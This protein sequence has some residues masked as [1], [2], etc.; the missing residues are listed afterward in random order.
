MLTRKS[1]V[2][3]RNVLRC[4]D[5]MMSVVVEGRRPYWWACGASGHMSKAY[6]NKMQYLGIANQQQRKQQ[7]FLARLPI[8][9][10]GRWQRRDGSHRESRTLQSSKNNPKGG[11]GLK[12]SGVRFLKPKNASTRERSAA[13]A[14]KKSSSS[15]KNN[16]KTGKTT[17]KRS[18]K[19]ESSAET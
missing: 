3:I 17:E 9:F 7:Q 2:R 19:E 13:Q 1:F 15:D 6:P 10:G 11:W 8:V 12:S 14:E 5:K 4:R 16:N 18:T